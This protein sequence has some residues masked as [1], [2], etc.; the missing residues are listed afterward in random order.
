[1]LL[2]ILTQKYLMRLPIIMVLNNTI[3]PVFEN[4][5]AVINNIALL[6]KYVRVV[7]LLHILSSSDFY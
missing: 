3:K 5:E 4:L 1:M 6:L 7:V 2:T